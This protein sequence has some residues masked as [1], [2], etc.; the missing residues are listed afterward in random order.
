MRLRTAALALLAA[1]AAGCGSSG[2]STPTIPPART[3]RLADFRP[4]RDVPPQAPVELSF[5]IL[6]PSG[7]TLTRY[8]RGPGPHTGIH[9]IVVRDDLATIIHRHPRVAPN[10]VLRQRLTFPAPGRYRVVVDAYPAGAD[11]PRNF[12]LFAS[13]RV[14]Q[15]RRPQRLPAYRPS[16]EADGYTFTIEKKPV[17]RAVE[18]AFLTVRV[19]DPHGRP[20]VLEP[21]YGALAHAILFRAGTLDYFHTHVCAPNAPGCTSLTRAPTGRPTAP[22]VLR[23]GLLLPVPGTWR[24]FL[25]TEIGG[26]IVTAPFTLRVG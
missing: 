8:R 1:A 5:R 17:L 20:P 22:G 24:L 16:V 25:Q 3:F 2:P 21:F 18:P 23:V 6:E 12:Q 13:V 19:R 26:R 15:A 14:G 4:A 11:V 7:Q 10:G 9:L